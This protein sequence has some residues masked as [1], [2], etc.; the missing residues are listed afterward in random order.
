SSTAARS[1]QSD[2]CVALRAG[3]VDPTCDSHERR[4]ALVHELIRRANQRVRAAAGRSDAL[5]GMATTLA[6]ALLGNHFM[7]IANVGDSR[8]Y[9]MRSGEL[10]CLTQDHH[11]AAE[12]TARGRLAG[13]VDLDHSTLRN[14]LSRALGMPGEIEPGLTHERLE[15]DDLYLLC[16]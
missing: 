10:Q 13:P 2:L 1:I 9:R 8:V 16:S 7:T 4:A 3:D 5:R 11:A 15:S 12:L 6:L 14:V